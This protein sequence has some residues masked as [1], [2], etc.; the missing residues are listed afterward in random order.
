MRKAIACQDEAL[1]TSK[2]A[3]EHAAST[4]RFLSRTLCQDP[5]IT[6]TR[7]GVH[8]NFVLPDSLMGS[9]TLHH[10]DLSI[11][12]EYPNLPSETFPRTFHWHWKFPSGAD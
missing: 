4:E 1:A 10:G 6:L 11:I 7:L 12:T 9:C 8:T 5:H 2:L 3:G